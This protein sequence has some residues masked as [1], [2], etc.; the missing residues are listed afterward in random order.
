MRPWVWHGACASTILMSPR[1]ILA[2]DELLDPPVGID[3]QI[4]NHIAAGRSRPRRT[5]RAPVNAVADGSLS[6]RPDEASA[7][8]SAE[9]SVSDHLSLGVRGRLS[10]GTTS[11]QPGA[12]VDRDSEQSHRTV[13]LQLRMT[14]RR[15][16]PAARVFKTRQSYRTL[17]RS[18][19][20]CRRRKGNSPL[21][22]PA[23]CGVAWSEAPV[24][25]ARE[26]DE[27]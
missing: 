26:T 13:Y 18:Q 4:V 8:R 19:V 20:G 22:L 24:V 12:R 2:L 16:V 21:R 25:R 7:R 17:V 5:T 1:V 27:D 9:R 15:D 14:G 11:R 10:S 6:T 23:R 3:R